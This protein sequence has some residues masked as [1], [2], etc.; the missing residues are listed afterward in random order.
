[1]AAHCIY[2]A[3]EGAKANRGA[4]LITNHED[5]GNRIQ[6]LEALVSSLVKTQ[7]V[8]NNMPAGHPI[9]DDPNGYPSLENALQPSGPY[10]A[11]VAVGEGHHFIGE[12]HWAAVLRDVSE[13]DE[14]TRATPY[15]T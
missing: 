13:T 6:R 5:M 10:G 3:D 8:G 9:A 1:M 15:I 12:S 11:V 4:H 2:A 14:S 7:A